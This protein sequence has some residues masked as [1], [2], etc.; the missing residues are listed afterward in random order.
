MVQCVCFV[1]VS[2]IAGGLFAHPQEGGD[3]EEAAAEIVAAFQ[4]IHD[5]EVPQ[6]HLRYEWHEQAPNMVDPFSPPEDTPADG[7]DVSYPVE[8]LLGNDLLGYRGY[9]RRMISKSK[10]KPGLEP[11]EFL[12]KDDRATKMFFE[13]GAPV[14]AT[15]SCGEYS[16]PGVHEYLIF[17]SLFGLM[18]SEQ[19]DSVRP[20]YK[21]FKEASPVGWRSEKDGER[22]VFVFERRIS[23]DKRTKVREWHVGTNPSVQL[24]AKIS[25]T[26]TASGPGRRTSVDEIR[27]EWGSLDGYWVPISMKREVYKEPNKSGLGVT[28]E[29]RLT[30][31]DVGEDVDPSYFAITIPDDVKVFDD[32]AADQPPTARLAGNWLMIGVGLAL[33]P[34]AAIVVWGIKLRYRKV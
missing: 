5:L 8:V 29:W 19:R 9:N 10:P 20:L 4:E 1:I 33:L 3:I 15:L 14:Q 7:V 34:L 24:L 12:V 13:D 32:C 28:Q 22:K 11:Y 6:V 31:F 2:A 27:Y 23:S 16:L 18:P 26:T 21:T 25:R 17:S 30:K